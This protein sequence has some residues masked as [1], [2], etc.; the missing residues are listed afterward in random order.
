MYSL[1]L[2]KHSC[3]YLVWD[4]VYRGTSLI[5]KRPPP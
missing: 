2:V 3:E 4:L 1:L 5:R